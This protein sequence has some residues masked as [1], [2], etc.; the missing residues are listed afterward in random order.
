MVAGS[1]HKSYILLWGWNGWE[2]LI[3]VLQDQNY[4]TSDFLKLQ[5][6]VI[7]PITT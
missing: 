3:S 2:I 4:W 1:V 5:Q 6:W 7:Y